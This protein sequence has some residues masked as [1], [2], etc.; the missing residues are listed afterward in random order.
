MFIWS[1]A[2]AF[3][4]RV[5][6]R[7]EDHDRQRSR[8]EFEAGIRA[9]LQWLGLIA[10]VDHAE[11]MSYYRQSDSD[12]VYAAAAEQ[13]A[14][15]E[16][17]YACR[18]SRKTIAENTESAQLRYP[19]TCAETD[20]SFSETPARRLRIRRDSVPFIDL[21]HGVQTQRPSEQCGDLL[22]R[23]RN[24]CWTYQFTVVVDDIRH[25]VNVIIRGDDLLDS[26]GR[27]ILVARSLGSH[28]TPLYVHHPLI[29][30]PDGAKLSKSAGD[31]GIAELRRAGAT[32]AE[33]LGLA[34]WSS[35]MQ[36]TPEPIS[37]EQLGQLWR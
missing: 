17:I 34:A 10:D 27:Q 9:D 23:D 35:G 30:R 3:H 14:E 4:G 19:G 37:A 18:C 6:L 8:A 20:V 33:V 24:G 12:H 2:R 7:I 1:V 22:I 13:L 21:R 29:M 26:T 28:A 11:P 25:G 15:Q 32:A 16:L 31:M 36:D 5:L